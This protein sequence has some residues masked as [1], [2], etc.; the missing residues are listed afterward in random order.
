M[1]QCLV[2]RSNYQPRSSINTRRLALRP[3]LRAP[4]T[5]STSLSSLAPSELKAIKANLFTSQFRWAP[6]TFAK[7]GMDL[8]N[9]TMYAATRLVD[10][11]LQ[12][13]AVPPVEGEERPFTL[14]EDDIQKVRR[15]VCLVSPGCFARALTRRLLAGHLPV[16]DAVGDVYRQ[17]IR[18]V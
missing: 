1:H 4:V 10:E 9:T 16:R 2:A 17:A 14:E 5:M 8:A 6:E 7:G 13:L 12:Q 15:A 18:L 3:L 11:T